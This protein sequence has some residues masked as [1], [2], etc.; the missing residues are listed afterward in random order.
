MPL[1][2]RKDKDLEGHLRASSPP[3]SKTPGRAS[4]LWSVTSSIF[5]VF[6]LICLSRLPFLLPCFLGLIPNSQFYFWVRLGCKLSELYNKSH[7][8]QVLG[9]SWG[10]A[11][12][13]MAHV[14][15]LRDSDGRAG[16]L[17]LGGGRALPPL[18]AETR[19]EQSAV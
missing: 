12:K 9:S 2:K 10:M 18:P 3:S 8:S 7:T 1:C 13:S 5:C 19:Q 17:G 15:L 6:L 16:T 11:Q 14:R 4:S